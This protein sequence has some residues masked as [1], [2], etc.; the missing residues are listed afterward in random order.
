MATIS[1]T[2][3]DP[4]DLDRSDKDEYLQVFG[5]THGNHYV[6]KSPSYSPGN[7]A[8]IQVVTIY[9]SP[10]YVPVYGLHGYDISYGVSEGRDL[11]GGF[12]HFT[13]PYGPFGFWANL[14]HDRK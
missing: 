10:G 3:S 7:V 2:R 9:K 14:Y 6:D 4:Q 13:G 5:V 11:L 1:L 12:S 8:H